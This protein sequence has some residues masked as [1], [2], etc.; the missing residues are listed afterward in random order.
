MC[1]YYNRFISN[2]SSILAPLY[3]LTT[4]NVPF[5]WNTVHEQAFSKIK[6]ALS[7]ANLLS[8]YNPDS[9]L[10]LEVDASPVGIG[11]VLK[12]NIEGK[13]STIAFASKKLSQSECNYS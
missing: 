12:K 9:E 7:N 8:N 13:I 2:F 6:Q 11:S 3:N 1:V 4:N 5:E 10:I